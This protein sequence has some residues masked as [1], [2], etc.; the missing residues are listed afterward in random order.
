M[1][2]EKMNEF[3]D[4][5]A[6]TYDNHMLIDLQLTEFYEQIANCFKA[7]D[8]HVSLIDLGCGTGIQL[9]RLFDKI[10]NS[11]IRN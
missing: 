11:N 3:F 9:E 8:S 5:R 2:L 7:S 4:K 10:P 6:T 1:S